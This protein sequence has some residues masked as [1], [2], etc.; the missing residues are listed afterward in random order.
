M[1]IGPFQNLVTLSDDSVGVRFHVGSAP[2]IWGITLNDKQGSEQVAY[3]KFSERVQGD[4]QFLRLTYEDG[5][6]PCELIPATSGV[7]GG[8][9]RTSAVPAPKDNLS[10]SFNELGFVCRQGLDLAKTPHLTAS[11]FSS[12]SGPALN[13]GEPLDLELTL[14]RWIPWVDNGRLFTPDDI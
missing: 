7:V 10:A 4:P 3:V 8:D 12:T 1:V 5:A 11:G 6:M 2:R 13:H 9:D 14:S